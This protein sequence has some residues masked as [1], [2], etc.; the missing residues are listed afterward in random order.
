V[1]LLTA[2]FAVNVHCFQRYILAHIQPVLSKNL[3]QYCI[4]A[5]VEHFTKFWVTSQADT[6]LFLIVFLL[7]FM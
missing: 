2:G 5:F 3:M 6:G 4:A 7:D 1:F